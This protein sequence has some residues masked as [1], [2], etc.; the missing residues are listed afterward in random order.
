MLQK[1]QQKQEDLQ[2]KE[3]ARRAALASTLEEDMLHLLHVDFD[4]D[5]DPNSQVVYLQVLSLMLTLP[6]CH[7]KCLELSATM[8]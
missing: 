6:F 1:R 7:L 8:S 4:L 2:K 3:D 5:E